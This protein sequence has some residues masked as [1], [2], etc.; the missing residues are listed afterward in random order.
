MNSRKLF[1][2]FV[3][4]CASSSYSQR[5]QLPDSLR[6]MVES[7]ATAFDLR[8]DIFT[9]PSGR[10]VGEGWIYS[11][12]FVPKG[13]TVRRSEAVNQKIGTWKWYRKNGTLD[14]DEFTP[15]SDS[16]YIHRTYYSKKGK[17]AFIKSHRPCD[18]KVRIAHHAIL[19]LPNHF[20]HTEYYKNSDQIKIKSEQIGLKTIGEYLEYY[21]NGNLKYK[22]YY[23]ENSKL[24]GKYLE[25]NEDGSLKYERKYVNGKIQNV[26]KI[27]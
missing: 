24:H 13:S 19:F 18:N 15:F 25:W 27:E 11:T 26:D 3:F 22:V 5:I 16:S 17:I 14:V 1:F 4:L 2:V 20:V 23:N 7:D 9:Y 8:Y 21:K 10:V 12:H 6:R